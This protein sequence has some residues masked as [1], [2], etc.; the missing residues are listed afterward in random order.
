MD[1]NVATLNCHGQ[2]RLTVQKQLAIQDF[3]K[4]YNIDIIFLQET[5]FNKETFFSCSFV[6]NNFSFD[7]NNTSNK[8]GTACLIKNSMSVSN[9]NFYSA[10]RVITFDCDNITICNVYPM[11]GTHGVSRHDREHL[12]SAVLTNVL[13]D[14]KE[15]GIVG[16]DCNCISIKMDC[17]QNPDGKLLPYLQML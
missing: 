1:I 5:N 12:I 15:C 17:S 3:I 16:G 4:S 9:I 11:S 8:Y 2:T 7:F 13:I 14:K 10:G 6:K